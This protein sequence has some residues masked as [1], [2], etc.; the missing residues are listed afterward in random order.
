MN[1]LFISHWCST[2]TNNCCYFIHIH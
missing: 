1:I 2:F